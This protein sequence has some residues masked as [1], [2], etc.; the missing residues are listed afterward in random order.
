MLTD[1]CAGTGK[2]ELFLK[3]AGVFK[4]LKDPRIIW[5]G[6]GPSNELMILYDRVISGLELLNIHLENRPFNPHLTLGRIKHHTE[7][8]ALKRLLD[9]YHDTVLQKFPV[10]EVILFQSVLLQTGPVYTP[11]QRIS[12]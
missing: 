11:I 4:N 3:G 5:T 2:F 7:K 1:K 8:E 12:L 10:D 9:Q 6:I